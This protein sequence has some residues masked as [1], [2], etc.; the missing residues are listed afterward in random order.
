[1]CF[2]I[3]G[4]TG[5]KTAGVSHNSA[6]LVGLS[7]LLFV[8]L[9]TLAQMYKNHQR[10]KYTAFIFIFNNIIYNFIFGKSV[11]ILI[12]FY[13]QRKRTF[14]YPALETIVHNISNER[15]MKG[16]SQAKK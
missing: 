4:Q 6:V 1:M 7:L 16:R 12:Y 15:E 3:E 2:S 11:I 8:L 9:L 10:V 13:P 5:Q 14:Q